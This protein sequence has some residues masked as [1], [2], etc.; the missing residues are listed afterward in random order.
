MLDA[1]QCYRQDQYAHC[2]TVNASQD[3]YRGQGGIDCRR[4]IQRGGR[5]FLLR[6][7]CRL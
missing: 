2:L 1:K 7:S 3:S 4:V 5:I 6:G